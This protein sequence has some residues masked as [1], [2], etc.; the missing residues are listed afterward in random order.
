MS[1]SYCLVEDLGASCLI[2]PVGLISLPY[3]NFKGGWRDRHF[4]LNPDPYH[5]T[6]ANWDGR[7]YITASV[8]AILETIYSPFYFLGRVTRDFKGNYPEP[9]NLPRNP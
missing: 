1:D 2:A 4:N 5:H 8:L 3:A 9:Q 7:D 6:K